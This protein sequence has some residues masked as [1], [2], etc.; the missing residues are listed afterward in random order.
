MEVFENYGERK[1]IVLHTLEIKEIPAKTAFRQKNS[2]IG[3]KYLALHFYGKNLLGV[4]LCENKTLTWT[5][6]SSPLSPIPPQM[7]NGTTRIL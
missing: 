1:K 7:A 6:S 4:H 5:R 3:K 2:Y